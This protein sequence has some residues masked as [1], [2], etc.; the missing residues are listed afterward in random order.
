ML[1]TVLFLTAAG[2][3]IPATLTSD[4][5]IPNSNIAWTI[6]LKACLP[7]P[8]SSADRQQ[9]I[10]SL[11][12]AGSVLRFSLEEQHK[13]DAMGHVLRLRG[14]DNIYTV[15]VITV[16]Q[17]WTGLHERAVLLISQP[18]LTLLNVQELQ[19]LAAHELGHE[20]VWKEYLDAKTRKDSKRVRELELICDV[21]AIRTLMEMGVSP[22]R[23][24]TATENIFWYNRQRLGVA[25]N[26]DNYPSMEQRRQLIKQSFL[27]KR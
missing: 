14:R 25:L 10:A 6:D 15:K 22:N 12:P 5:S 26:E 23:L 19:A 21:I 18:A 27:I 13:L 9:V 20:Y 7:T 24:Q 2:Q 1:T 8:I 16:P 11:P 17:A 4:C 3:L